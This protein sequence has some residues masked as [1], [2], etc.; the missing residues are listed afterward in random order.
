[1]ARIRSYV[2]HALLGAFDRADLRHARRPSRARRASHDRLA[3]C[4]SSRAGASTISTPTR[5]RQPPALSARASS[6]SA[7]SPAACRQRDHRRGASATASRLSAR[8]QSFRSSS[9]DALRDASRRRRR[10][11][12]IPRQRAGSRARHPSGKESPVYQTTTVAQI[13]C[14]EAASASCG[15][16]L[17]AHE[18]TEQRD[19]LAARRA[20][21]PAR[22]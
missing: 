7:P 22:G 2:I 6:G 1:M 16:T 17:A 8:G 21:S 20:G 3:P 4:L 10:R 13:A 18:L 5:R 15:P 19:A 11:G 14:Q 9:R 12:A